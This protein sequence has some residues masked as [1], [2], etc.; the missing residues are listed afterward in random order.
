MT[1]ENCKR[2]VQIE[3]PVEEVT[4]ETA[5]VTSQFARVAKLPGFRPGK[6]PATLIRRKFWSDIRS[7]VAQ[8]L[9]PK[10]F[11]SVVKEQ[12]L[13]TA[14]PPR[15]EAL[16]FEAD[17][18]LTCKVQFE[19]LPSFELQDYRGL[20]TSEQPAAV[21]EEEIDRALNE[22]R[23][24][25]A[26]Y[27]VIKGRPAEDG[28]FAEVQIQ[29]M[30]KKGSQPETRRATVELGAEG[31]RKE[32]TENL[33]GAAV[34][35]TRE[36]QVSQPAEDSS[37]TES[38]PAQTHSYRVTLDA[39]KE[40]V[41]PPLND[42]LAR[43]LSEFETLEPFKEQI[44]DHLVNAKKKQAHQEA[45]QKLMDQLIERHPMP[46][47]DI[48]VESELEGRTRKAIQDLVAH[49]IDPRVARIDWKQ[50]R[51]QWQ[52]PAEKS[53]QGHLI[54]DRIA[55]VEKIAVSEE[56]LDEKVRLLAR[57]SGESPAALKTRLTEEGT[58][59]KLKSSCRHEK[60]LDLIYRSAKV[61]G[62][63]EPD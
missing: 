38:S 52:R 13:A 49:G 48:L 45:K 32:F 36:F 19:V 34:G 37:G 20:E 54:L 2:E 39:L 33:R 59:D 17:K 60:A 23:E 50:L 8:K 57:D 40:K 24:R 14:G 63:G 21:T 51:E 11:K 25:V 16:N 42:E 27:E 1:A 6:A 15:F 9:L 46:L 61:I 26:T 44:R 31:T 53:V 43:T 35:E 62:K 18:P 41:L 58:L 10:Y 3:V 5:A 28:D 22:M 7:E 4:R 56:E 30:P 55:D 12:N 47:P 29:R